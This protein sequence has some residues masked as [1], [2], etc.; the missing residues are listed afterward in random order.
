MNKPLLIN[1]NEEKPAAKEN[2]CPYYDVD[3]IEC[4]AATSKCYLN[5]TT[6]M[7]FCLGD[8]F[9]NCAVFLAKIL[10]GGRISPPADG[11]RRRRLTL[12][13]NSFLV[14]SNQHY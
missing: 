14:D 1:I 13:G 11:K 9:E 5:R 4:C 2:H 6:R 10:R 7:R 8:E 3:Q 12:V